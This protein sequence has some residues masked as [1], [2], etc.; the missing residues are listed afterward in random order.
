MDKARKLK[1]KI[2]NIYNEIIT[3]EVFLYIQKNYV[4]VFINVITLF[5][6]I[7]LRVSGIFENQTFLAAFLPI[8]MNILIMFVNSNAVSYKIRIMGLSVDYMVNKYGVTIDDI[9][10]I[11]ISNK[12][13]KGF[14]EPTRTF[15][16]ALEKF[17]Q[18]GS[19]EQRRR[20]AEALPALYR[21]NKKSTRLIIE[22]KLRDDYDEKRWH[23]DNRR[24]TIEALAY[25][26][27]SENKFVKSCF[28][29]RNN[30]SIYTIIAILEIIFFTDKFQK[31]EQD[32]LLMSMR[33][34]IRDFG[35][36]EECNRFIDE[37]GQ[38]VSKIPKERKKIRVT[39]D[40]FK[41]NFQETQNQ[42][43]KILLAKN[44]LYI[45]PYGKKCIAYNKC[46]DV[47][48]CAYCVLD[49]FKM[50]FNE[51]NHANIRRP[52]ARENVF[53]CL[54]SLL[55]HSAWRRDAYEQILS[56]IKQEDEII[57]VTAFD[58][59]HKIFE[60]DKD[61]YNEIMVHCLR[62]PDEDKWKDLRERAKHVKEIIAESG[63]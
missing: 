46:H 34:G 62:L 39:Y 51:K 48:D 21:L 45:C 37:A 14:V 56:L 36:G 26:P 52:M 7:V 47:I 20:A 13:K 27:K 59:I 25:F 42:Y 30:D 41:R 5:I 28:R 12:L 22:E 24:R 2:C 11:L 17:C 57:S 54:L 4:N 38:L 63:I 55:K 32:E 50:C 43:I 9:L 61:L 16:K 19:Y 18:E 49:F 3:N 29:V 8:L 15:F 35:L 44:I 53:N 40:Y 58:Y 33:N 10:G 23:D 6:Y 60:I 31:E 1:E